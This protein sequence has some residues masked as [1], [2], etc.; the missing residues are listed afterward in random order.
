MPDA[1]LESASHSEIG[2]RQSAFSMSDKANILLVDDRPEKLLSLEAVLDDLGENIV[3]AHSG[4]E[5][6]RH[7]LAT[8]FAVILLDV[9]MPGM[10]GFETAS[11]IRQ[12]KR[13]EHTPII[14]I[15]AFGDEIHATRG[16]QL[17]AVD[18]ILA[19]V[20]PDVL[21]T[22]VAV[23]V[24]LFKK[25]EQVRRQADSLQRRASQLQ[26]LAAASLAING[27]ASMATTLQSTT[28]AARDIVGAHQA[29]TLCTVD[30][31][32]TSHPRP[33]ALDVLDAAAPPAAPA[34]TLVSFS[35][36]YAD[37]T[38]RPLDLHQC[39]ATTIGRSSVPVRLA[40][41]ELQ[42]HVDWPLV[43]TLCLP[44]VRGV[45]AAP[46]VGRDGR[47]MG[48]VV[49][50]DKADGGDFTSD[51]EAILVQLTQ[52]ASVAI[53]NVI[54]SKEREAN[55]LKDEFLATL[56]HELRTPL[57]AIV[58]WT[59]LLQMEDLPDETVHGLKVIDRNAK[60]QAKL[61][62]DL[63]DVSRITT[64]K[65]RVKL[66]ATSLRE[67]V[68]GVVDAVRPTADGKGV[69]LVMPPADAMPP[70]A[71][72]GDPDRLQQVVWNLLTNAVKFTPTGGKVAIGLAV[73]DHSVC[74]SVTDTG[75]GIDPRFL[76][77]VFDRFR[78]ADST[79]TR[80]YGGL[81]I[82]LTIVRHIVELHGG[83][84]EANSPGAG[85][86]AT[87]TVR[88][89]LRGPTGH[90]NSTGDGT[91]VALNGSTASATSGSTDGEADP[92]DLRGVMVLVV[93]DEADAR[94]VVA[95]MLRRAGARVQTSPS[96]ADALA[97][98]SN[99]TSATRPAVLVSDI[100]M[101]GDDGFALIAGVR[102]MPASAGGRVPAIALTAY[103]RAEDRA[104]SLA[105]GFD[106]HL[107]KPVE[108]TTLLSTVARLARA[109]VALNNLPA[110]P[111]PLR[112]S[113]AASTDAPP[114]I[115]TPR[116]SAPRHAFSA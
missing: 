50:S 15:T 32:P 89:P 54:F 43:S 115:D 72:E 12:R 4:R 18:Y 37:W 51:D 22:K 48:L 31:G 9:N 27:A 1:E 55:R 30:D 44:P 86:G 87:F 29:F 11:L 59:Q 46:L 108:A 73:D 25:S 64:G 77:Y 101:P 107:V 79:S 39:A 90:S 57:N 52:M 116:H 76:P 81:G 2:I 68:R 71:V 70:A 16:Y 53:E 96:T 13:S 84:V 82:G 94:D 69:V 60:S 104:R 62:E 91:V 103:A 114:T 38:N 42:A 58:G 109:A 105:A 112:D 47:R 65:L 8:D 49:L 19:P 99:A 113:D 98:L 10:D 28:D 75:N 67:I 110:G 20:M 6:L 34:H 97:I 17:G 14:F 102:A 35:D 21:R 85:R 56:S 24:D 41:S 100:A 5:A 63:L 95:E 83:T 3:T 23:F 61:I 106:A 7:V 66:Q 45:L 33:A 78:Q 80:S 40:H 93:D 74:L 88:V 26:K 36:K 92:N 111:L